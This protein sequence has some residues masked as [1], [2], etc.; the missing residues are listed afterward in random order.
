MHLV[1]LDIDKK[2]AASQYHV[3]PLGAGLNA[4]YSP[5]AANSTLLTRF[6]KS[7][8]FRGQT[9]G[10]FDDSEF[11]S[12]DGSLTWV[13]ASGH[14]RMLDCA[15]G[16]PLLAQ[17]TSTLLPT[18]STT[19]N[20]SQAYTFQNDDERIR[21]SG[22]M[23]WE[24]QGDDH[25]W[26]ELRADL[27]SMIFCSP[28]GST[29]PEKLWWS[30]S[31]LGVHCTA[32]RE[33]DEGY[34]QLKEE[35]ASLLVRLRE[36]D[37]VDHDRTWWLSERDRLRSDLQHILVN[38]QL[39]NTPA[40]TQRETPEPSTPSNDRSNPW[41]YSQL[42]EQL[43]HAESMIDRWNQR[44]QTH[45]RLA[46]VQSL[47]QTRS[48]YRRTS[49]GSLIPTAERFLSELTSGAVRQL[50]AWA[51]E[52]SYL[53]AESINAGLRFDSIDSQLPPAHTRQRR[54]VDLAIRLAIAQSARS[55]VGRIPFMLEH[56]IDGFR[57]EPLEQ[58]L[59]VLANFSRDG[60]QILL[61]T[62][63][64]H[65]ARR[66]A[67]HGGSVARVHENLRYAKPHYVIDSDTDLGLHPVLDQAP[68][69]GNQTGTY[70]SLG[71]HA[72]HD[73]RDVNRHLEGLAVEHENESFGDAGPFDPWQTSAHPRTH[74]SSEPVVVQR[75]GRTYYLAEESSIDALPGMGTETLQRLRSVGAHRVGDLFA[76]PLNRLVNVTGLRPKWIQN[77]LSVAELMCKVPQMRAFDARVLVAC[78]VTNSKELAAQEPLVLAKRVHRFLTTEAGRML[79]KSASRGELV[80]LR[81]WIHTVYQQHGIHSLADGETLD[82]NWDKL[83]RKNNRTTVVRMAHPDPESDEDPDVREDAGQS[84][85]E[86]TIHP[87]RSDSVWK[88]YLDLNSPVVD[89]P[90]IGPKMAEKL[91][92]IEVKSIGDL[93][94]A[95]PAEVAQA[96]GE[97][98]VSESVVE[99]WQNQSMLVCRIPNLRGQ[100]AQLLVAAGFRTAESV[101]EAKADLLYDAIIRIASTKQGLRFLRGGNPPDR[102]RV[103]SWIEWSKHS[104]AVKAA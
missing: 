63:D 50:P 61:I 34:K 48:P 77:T 98:T 11:A 96:L 42:S 93:L 101:A 94:G 9:L 74:R 47:L 37:P 12:I 25:R 76:M 87:G 86:F 8:L 30:A 56:S 31:K 44:A 20:T 66:I 26:D 39:L 104:R 81:Q 41:D 65:I 7:L 52:A 73:Y 15:G 51:M 57:G 6:T 91:H 69:M 62:A 102:D 35:E 40:N 59:H 29:S 82:F 14:L 88:F 64:E 90:T 19:N 45:Q 80:R 4:I 1:R 54:L 103:K 33:L 46:Q 60:W 68:M 5:L 75:N 92:A 53:Q 24:G 27:L 18:Q 38:N 95:A 3:G 89:A 32:R 10:E 70:N 43:A 97:K 72:L 17:L 16:K 49:S 22:N 84:V 58:I 21:G 36:A 99:N 83:H 79:R 85:S 55:R 71:F 78:G 13:D 67:G 28:L 23:F 2:N 100:D